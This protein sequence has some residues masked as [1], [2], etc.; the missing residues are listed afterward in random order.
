M[1]GVDNYLMGEDELFG[2]L[3]KTLKYF[4]Y[5]ASLNYQNYIPGLGPRLITLW[6]KLWKK[7]LDFSK[8]YDI[9]NDYLEGTM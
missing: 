6:K 7:M 3:E 8:N 4:K 9:I 2:E 1:N 5:I